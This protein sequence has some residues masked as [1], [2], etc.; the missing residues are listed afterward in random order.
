MSLSQQQL[1]DCSNEKYRSYACR[2]GTKEG[3]FSYIA[4]NGGIDTDESYPYEAV[5]SDALPLLL[6]RTF[7]TNGVQLFSLLYSAV[8]SPTTRSFRTQF[9]GL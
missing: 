8:T 1:V 7:F 3:A 2:G 9:T 4:S 5:V 6:F